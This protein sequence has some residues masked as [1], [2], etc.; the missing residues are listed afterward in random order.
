[1]VA[2]NAVSYL[3]VADEAHKDIVVGAFPSLDAARSA[4]D[5]YNRTH[6]DA[7]CWI[8]VNEHES[9]AVG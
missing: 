1:M 9:V 3:V 7:F 2:S 6:P 5:Y 8:E 4:V